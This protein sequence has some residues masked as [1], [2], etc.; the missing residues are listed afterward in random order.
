VGEGGAQGGHAA[1]LI[2]C[3]QVSCWRR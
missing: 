3:G 1:A 2:V